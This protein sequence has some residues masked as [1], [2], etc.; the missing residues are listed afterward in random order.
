MS[1]YSL[2]AISIGP[3]QPFI[4]AARKTRDFWAGSSLLS[5]IARESAKA[6]QSTGGELIFPAPDRAEELNEA[7]YAVANKIVAI[8]DED[9]ETV[10]ENAVA[11]ARDCLNRRAKG[12]FNK[13]EHSI[14]RTLAEKQL[15][16]LLELYWA[17]APIQGEPQKDSASYTQARKAADALLAAR[18]NTR[19]FSQVALTEDQGKR[20]KCA[21]DG[22]RESVVLKAKKGFGEPLCGI[23][24]FKRHADASSWATA[25]TTHFA[26]LPAAALWAAP[27]EAAFDAFRSELRRLGATDTNEFHASYLFEE[28][29]SDTFDDEALNKARSALRVL[30]KKPG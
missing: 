10:A 17:S 9:P 8:V 15:E 18:K 3:V 20:P 2:I 11:A 21:I 19:D 25:T 1:T 28:R 4:A 5:E 14:D 27:H 22:I 12:V 29:L 23:C 13:F 16:T 7:D 6:I 26:A 30:R 24:F